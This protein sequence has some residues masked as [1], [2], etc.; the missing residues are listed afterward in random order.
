MIQERSVEHLVSC[1]DCPDVVWDNVTFKCQRKHDV[2]DARHTAHG[3]PFTLQPH[4]Y[5]CCETQTP[6]IK[7]SGE[8]SVLHFDTFQNYSFGD[9]NFWLI[10]ENEVG[11]DNSVGIG[12]ISRVQLA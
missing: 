7:M 8:N 5:M 1:S 10:L 11:R 2:S 12:L 6:F 3:T 9:I 4:Q